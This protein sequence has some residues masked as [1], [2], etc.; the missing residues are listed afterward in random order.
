MWESVFISD[1]HGNLPAL[2]AVL[3]DIRST[4]PSV[5][6]LCLG[7][8]VGKGPSNAACIDLVRENCTDVLRGNWDK[9]A[10]HSDRHTAPFIREQIGEERTDYL[11]RLPYLKVLHLYG[12]NIK[13]FHGRF[14]VPHVLW[15]WAKD[16]EWD[17]YIQAFDGGNSD[18]IGIG[19]TH[20]QF[21]R[22]HDG[23][24]LFNC[25]SVGNS[26]DGSNMAAY[27]ILRLYEN[28]GIELTQK[29]IPYDIDRELELARTTPGFPEAEK[30]C[31]EIRTA[32]YGGRR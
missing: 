18:I 26:V 8:I 19:D 10:V 30:Y 7:D 16:E 17:H 12:H 25:G 15:P 5:P 9:A 14:I 11:H 3:S 23:V 32:S 1:I 2:E 4:R 21:Q 28:G 24:F 31:V 27:S 29:R 6:I 13:L 20:W 22:V